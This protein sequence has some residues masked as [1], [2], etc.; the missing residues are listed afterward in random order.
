MATHKIIPVESYLNG[1]DV[2]H[3]AEK[4]HCVLWVTGK[5]LLRHRRTEIVLERLVRR[6]KLRAVR[7]GRKLVYCL[8]RKSKNYD[9]VGSLSKV[10]HG[11]ACTECIVRFYISKPGGVVV[12][13]RQ[14]FSHGVVPEFGILYPS[15][16]MLLVEYC[17]KSNYYFSGNIRSKVAA[18]AAHVNEIEERFHA[19]CIVCFVCD[20]DRSALKRDV[21]SLRFARPVGDTFPLLPLWFVDYKTFLSVP[22]GE[23]LKPQS[24]IYIFADGKEDSLV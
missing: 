3:W 24:K 12:P 9:E 21:G 14:F 10:I 5:E 7:Y 4:R 18:Y 20:I 15:G 1:F 2:F 8:P 16:T 6:K 13:E 22:L 19:R 11:L 17:T 23:A